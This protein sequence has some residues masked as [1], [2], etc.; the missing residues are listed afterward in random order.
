MKRT[1]CYII[2]ICAVRAIIRTASII[3][4]NVNIPLVYL[5]KVNLRLK[6]YCRN[7]REIKSISFSSKSVVR[8]DVSVFVPLVE[9]LSQRLTELRFKI[10]QLVRDLRDLLYHVFDV[11]LLGHDVVAALLLVSYFVHYHDVPLSVRVRILPC[12]DFYR[13]VSGLHGRSVGGR[14]V[15]DLRG[16]QR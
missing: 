11:V 13:K 2:A 10:D 14:H 6:I 9:Q 16:L 5:R 4:Y 12:R 3:H 8:T 15:L 7:C 1:K